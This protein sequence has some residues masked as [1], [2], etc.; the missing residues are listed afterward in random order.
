MKQRF[1]AWYAKE[2][3]KQIASGTAIPNVKIDTYASILKPKS[4]NWLIEHWTSSLKSLKLSS[5]VSERLAFLMHL[6][7]MDSRI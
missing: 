3:Q 4:A 5:M 6:K 7:L 2:V 1:Q